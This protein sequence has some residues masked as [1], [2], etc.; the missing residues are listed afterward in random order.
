[1]F[2]LV[3]FDIDGTLIFNNEAHLLAFNEMFKEL[4]EINI[5]L[6]E[7][8]HHGLTD[9][10]I[11][12]KELKNNGF[13]LDH[14]DARKKHIRDTLISYFSMFSLQ[15]SIHLIPGVRELLNRLK[16]LDII[17][18]LATGNIEEI[19][20]NKLK[21]TGIDAFFLTGGFGSD[22]ESRGKIVDIAIQRASQASGIHFTREDVLLIGDTP[23]DIKAARE[24]GISVLAVA[25][26]L[27]SQAELKKA[28]ADLVIKDYENL[29]VIM[30]YISKR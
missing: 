3:L 28:I 12:R 1:M 5:D 8:N 24:A 22:D 15:R 18:G 2:K 9:F 4:F 14:F 16:K 25:T 23:L 20:W 26:G 17:L 19:A 27:Y 6:R 10:L 30:N 11:V 21:S 29:E 7:T 13:S